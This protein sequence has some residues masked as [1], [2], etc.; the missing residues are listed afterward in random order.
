MHTSLSWLRGKTT[1]SVLEQKKI[2]ISKITYTRLYYIQQKS[3]LVKQH[4]GS[5]RL[6]HIQFMK[7]VCLRITT[8]NKQNHFLSFIPA[9]HSSIQLTISNSSLTSFSE[10]PRYLEVRV[11][12]ET[13]KNVVQHSV[14]TALANMVFPVPGGPT[15]STPFHGRRKP[16]MQSII[17]IF[18]ISTHYSLQHIKPGYTPSY[19][20]QQRLIVTDYSIQNT[21]EAYSHGLLHT[22]HNRGL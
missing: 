6:Q 11:E 7:M 12:D 17:F 1:D 16:C 19:K 8:P 9:N 15:I 14:T 13:L 10:S 21:T 22:K 2:S 5:Q 20:T 3:W 4:S 18:H